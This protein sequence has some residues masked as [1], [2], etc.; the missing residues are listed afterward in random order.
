MVVLL[1]LARQLRQPALLGQ[2]RRHLALQRRHLVVLRLARQPELLVLI[3]RGV[4][5]CLQRRKV[6][7]VTREEL[8]GAALRLVGSALLGRRHCKVCLQRALFALDALQLRLELLDTLVPLLDRRLQRRILVLQASLGSL[9]LLL[10]SCLLHLTHRK[11]LL[12]ARFL[13]EDFVLGSVSR[14]HPLIRQLRDCL[15]PKVTHGVYVI[16]GGI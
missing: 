10:E 11:H 13:R 15:H 5:P 8:L 6:L 3:L 14:L 9:Q 7:L 4:A 1:A 2:Q 12:N 16:G